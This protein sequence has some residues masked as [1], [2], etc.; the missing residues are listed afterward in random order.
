MKRNP[1]N[2]DFKEEVNEASF[3]RT[4]EKSID[5]WRQGELIADDGEVATAYDCS[6]M[7]K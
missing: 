3:D 1:G 4:A 7:Y 2:R 5:V 6:G